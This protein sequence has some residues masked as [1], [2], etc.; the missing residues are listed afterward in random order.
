[1][2]SLLMIGNSDLDFKQALT[3]NSRS[4]IKKHNIQYTPEGIGFELLV[5]K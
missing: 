3:C 2:H 4:M 1:M 5:V